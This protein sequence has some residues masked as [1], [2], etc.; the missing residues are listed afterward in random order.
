MTAWINER[1]IRLTAARGP[2]LPLGV[3][4]PSGALAVYQ[5]ILRRRPG[6]DIAA[7]RAVPGLAAQEPR[8]SRLLRGL[9]AG[10]VPRRP[11]RLR[12]ATRR[13]SAAAR[14]GAAATST[15]GAA[16]SQPSAGCAAIQRPTTAQSGTVTRSWTSSSPGKCG[17]GAGHRQVR[18]EDDDLVHHVDV[19]R[20]AADVAERRGERLVGRDVAREQQEA[21]DAG[22]RDR[23]GQR[24]D[25]GPGARVD[26]VGCDEEERRARAGQRRQCRSTSRKTSGRNIRPSQKIGNSRA[27]RSRKGRPVQASVATLTQ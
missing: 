3:L 19:E 2:A 4:H 18:V 14:R 23:E 1:G 24:A 11:D 25:V 6:W 20:G 13:A 17:A 16:N 22:Q 21:G 5:A 9:S 7:L 26:D 15:Q 10:D 12:V 8:W 27:R